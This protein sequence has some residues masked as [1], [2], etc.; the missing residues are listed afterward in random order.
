M[1]PELASNPVA[2]RP[3]TLVTLH[4]ARVSDLCKAEAFTRWNVKREQRG[5]GDGKPSLRPQMTRV[6][7]SNAADQDVAN[8]PIRW[9]LVKL[10]TP[11][12]PVQCWHACNGWVGLTAAHSSHVREFRLPA[13]GAFRDQVE[14]VPHA[15]EIIARLEAGV[16][17]AQ[18]LSGLAPKHRDARP[19]A[20]V[21]AVA[22]VLAEPVALVRDHGKFPAAARRE[23]LLL[24]RRVGR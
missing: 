16:G 15:A 18:D 1:S 19:R 5:S 6:L 23:R 3:R 12:L 24:R 11:S 2:Q 7:S 21:D 4:D 20:A 14:Q 22:H 9:R 17:D 8:E 10:E 13:G